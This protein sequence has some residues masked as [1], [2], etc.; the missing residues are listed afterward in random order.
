[1]SV[2]AWPSDGLAATFVIVRPK[3]HGRAN[4]HTAFPAATG[5]GCNQRVRIGSVHEISCGLEAQIS[6]WIGDAA[7]T[8]FDPLYSLNQG[9]YRAGA[10]VDVQ[11]SAIAVQEQDT[12]PSPDDY[13]FCAPVKDVEEYEFGGIPV[14]KFR[15]TVM[16]IQDCSRSGSIQM[17]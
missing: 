9:R 15:S 6:G 17:T 13:Q 7:V 2:I 5:G 10:R 11:M 14:W 1:V 12:F 8:F 3:K 4:L 16:R